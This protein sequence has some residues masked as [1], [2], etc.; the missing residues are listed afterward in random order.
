M[1]CRGWASAPGVL[2]APASHQQAP[3]APPATTSTRQ[4][5][6]DLWAG[7]SAAPWTSRPRPAPIWR[8]RSLLTVLSNIQSTYQT[9]QH[10]AAAARR[11]RAT[12]RGT[13]SAYDHRAA[14]QLQSGAVAA[15]HRSQQRR[16]Q[17]PVDRI[18][19]VGQRQRHAALSSSARQRT[20][21]SA[22]T[23]SRRKS[24]TS[25]AERVRRR[26]TYRRLKPPC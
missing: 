12:P 20:S 14:R 7:L 2:S 23:D 22:A 11:R 8:A 3:P 4:G 6:A 25:C 17:H 21:A 18:G 1:R 24:E 9:I 10:A 5:H 15:G 16:Q 19:R 13:A 26:R